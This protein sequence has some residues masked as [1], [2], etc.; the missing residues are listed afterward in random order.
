[1]TLGLRRKSC[2]QEQADC[3]LIASSGLFDRAWY[4]TQYLGE[5]HS[6]TDPVLDYVRSG[7]REGR[8]PN[9]LFD[10]EWY[11]SQYPDVKAA[12]LNPLVHYLLHGAT[13]GRDP[14][15]FFDTQCYLARHP[16]LNAIALKGGSTGN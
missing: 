9:A 10:S 2:D 3:E 14:S 4:F 6:D 12:G 16:E 7:A 15:P 5:A 13:Q 8:N 1:M 11:C